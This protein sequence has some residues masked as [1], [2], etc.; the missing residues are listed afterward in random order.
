MQTGRGIGQGQSMT[1]KNLP[2]QIIKLTEFFSVAFELHL[3]KHYNFLPVSFFVCGNLL[4]S[5]VSTF[6]LYS[7]LLENCPSNNFA[8]LFSCQH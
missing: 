8:E 2:A 6:V 4:F 7:V 1:A 5:T 3:D